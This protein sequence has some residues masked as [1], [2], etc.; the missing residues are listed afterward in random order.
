MAAFE[1]RPLLRA[2]PYRDWRRVHSPLPVHNGNDN[3]DSYAFRATRDDAMHAE[4]TIEL[5]PDSP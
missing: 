3:G 2:D 5:G 4:F 1:A